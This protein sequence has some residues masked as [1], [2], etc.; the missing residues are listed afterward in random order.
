MGAGNYSMPMIR[1][2][3]NLQT[4]A[5]QSSIRL[6]ATSFRTLRAV[7]SELIRL[8]PK[9]DSHL[10]DPL[11][12]LRKDVPIFVNGRNPRLYFAGIDSILNEEDV[13][14]IFSSIASG[15]MNVEVLRNPQYRETASK[16]EE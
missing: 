14:S 10:L 9:M 15:R 7:L 12:N 1:F 5:N 16:G 11:G 4:V 6:D 8:Y 2:Y 13:I 3:A